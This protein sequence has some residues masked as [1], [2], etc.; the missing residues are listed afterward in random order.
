MTLLESLDFTVTD[1]TARTVDSDQLPRVEIMWGEE[2]EFPDDEQQPLDGTGIYQ[3]DLDLIVTNEAKDDLADFMD[4][5]IYDIRNIIRT[6]QTLDSNCMRARY[7]S[8][9]EPEISL[10]GNLP[11]IQFTIRLKVLYAE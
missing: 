11:V 4:E 6:D 7:L 9:S 3:A 2:E 10:E 8:A 5:S 1:H